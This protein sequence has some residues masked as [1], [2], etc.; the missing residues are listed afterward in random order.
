MFGSWLA[1]F[2]PPARSRLAPCEWNEVIDEAPVAVV[3]VEAIGPCVLATAIGMTNE[4]FVR[5]LPLPPL[6]TLP[7]AALYA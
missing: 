1:S 5:S 6:S 4:A 2:E 3:P 7:A